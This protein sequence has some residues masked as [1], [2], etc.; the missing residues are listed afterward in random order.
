MVGSY[1]GLVNYDEKRRISA[2]IKALKAPSIYIPPCPEGVPWSN[3][4]AIGVE[5]LYRME[6]CI[7]ADEIGIGKTAQAIK[8]M[9]LIAQRDGGNRFLVVV[10]ASLLLQWV[11]EIVKYA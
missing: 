1:E 6:R 4:Q 8:L 11:Q 2:E 3:E 5:F 7:L 10:S 9:E